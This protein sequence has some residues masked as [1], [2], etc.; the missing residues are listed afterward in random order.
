VQGRCR[1]LPEASTLAA[2]GAA[3]SGYARRGRR[4]SA[5]LCCFSHTLP[6]CGTQYEPIPLAHRRRALAEP[7]LSKSKGGLALAALLCALALFAFPAVLDRAGF[8]EKPRAR[9][10]CAR[11]QI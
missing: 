5:Q 9:S 4:S 11:K 10:S 7:P 8:G 3:A 2:A 1:P 6:G